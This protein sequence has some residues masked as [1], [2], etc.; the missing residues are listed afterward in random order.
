MNTN[1]LKKKLHLTENSEKK[2]SDTVLEAEQKT[3]GEIVVAIT[4]ESETY[5]FYE[6]FFSLI[7]G[8]VV[9]A[10][11]II[12]SSPI[13]NWLETKFW[14]MPV[15]VFTVVV[16]SISFLVIAIVFFISNI[17]AI[18]RK[19]IPRSVQFK[20]VTKRAVRTFADQ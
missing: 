16:G 5:S 20:A 11:L 4:P 12:F 10:F 2:I 14:E 18:D 7:V 1:T 9:F 8:I 15:W 19:I 6:L 3:T 13:I 17:V